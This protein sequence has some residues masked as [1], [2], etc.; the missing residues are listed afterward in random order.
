L[1]ST[2]TKP[3]CNKKSAHFNG[4]GIKIFTTNVPGPIL[5]KGHTMPFPAL[6]P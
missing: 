3:K 5:C 4:K 1:F 2:V 6:Y